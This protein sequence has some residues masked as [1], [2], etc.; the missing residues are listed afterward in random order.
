MEERLFW[1]GITMGAYAW[2]T[3]RW[4]PMGKLDD[5][6]P[7]AAWHALFYA[8][9]GFALTLVAVLSIESR[10]SPSASGL[11]SIREVLSGL[12]GAA[13]LGLWG[14]WSGWTGGAKAEKRREIL[15]ED[16][17]WAETVF[18]A[19]L[20][21]AVLM[22][23]VVQAFKIPSG[24]MESTLKIGDHLF[25][26]KFLYGVR[27][28]FTKK[29]V[30]RLRPVGRGDIV[31]FQ[32]PTDDPNEDH[33]GGPQ[34]GKDFIKRVVGVPGDTVEVRNGAAFV[35]GQKAVADGHVQYLDPFRTPKPLLSFGGDEYQKIWEERQLDKTLGDAMRDNFGPIH[36][37]PGE[38]FVMG[39]NR[40][41][42]CDGRF[43]GPVP[44]HYL[45]GKAWFIYWP[46]ARIGSIR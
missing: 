35:N 34:Y 36:V 1:I 12:A 3:K 40:D 31:V 24:S 38:Y 28:P 33:C 18:S 37:P 5:R 39:D 25:V 7:A 14:Y 45:K 23:F 11:I 2:A 27:I 44:D 41:R 30:L 16:L 32:F 10:M 29:R 9:A 17:E 21:A 6:K 43:W 42:S 8:L 15:A 4:R 19:V 26:N 22:Y 13:A 20:L 46:P